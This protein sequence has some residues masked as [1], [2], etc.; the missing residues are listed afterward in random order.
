LKEKCG[1][2]EVDKSELK[3]ILENELESLIVNLKS[4]Y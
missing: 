2:E 3:N 1:K 4:E